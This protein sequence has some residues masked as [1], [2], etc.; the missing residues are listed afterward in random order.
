MRITTTSSWVAQHFSSLSPT[1]TSRKYPSLRLENK[2]IRESET[3]QKTLEEIASAF[4]D[5]VV[6]VSDRDIIN[7][8]AI[9][10]GKAGF[11]HLESTSVPV[12]GPR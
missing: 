2:L 4:G 3:K 8:Q 9:L 12:E 7:E 1:S 10:E 6:L 11:G 5:K